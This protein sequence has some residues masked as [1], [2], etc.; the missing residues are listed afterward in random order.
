M[1]KNK[2]ETRLIDRD[3]IKALCSCTDVQLTYILKYRK[4]KFPAVFHRGKYRKSFYL[5]PEV[6]AWLEATDITS[7]YAQR[8]IVTAQ[9]KVKGKTFTAGAA[10][11]ITKKPVEEITAILARYKNGSYGRRTVPC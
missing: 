7:M 1:L 8:T 6:E 9:G 3:G 5:Y 10:Q 2:E 4:C 11:F